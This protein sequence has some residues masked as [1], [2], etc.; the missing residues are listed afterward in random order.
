MRAVTLPV[1]LLLSVWSVP[2]LA[3]ANAVVACLG[4]QILCNKGCSKGPTA[5]SCINLCTAKAQACAQNGGKWDASADDEDD[6]PTKRSARRQTRVAAPAEDEEEEDSSSKSASSKSSSR[7]A[8]RS[9][10]KCGTD[11]EF[12]HSWPV[13]KDNDKFKFKFRVSSDDCDQYSCRGYVNYRIHF[14][15]LSGGSSGKSTLVRYT[16][17]K[18]QRSIEVT[19]ETFP[20]GANMAINVRDVEIGEVSCSSP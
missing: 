10:G 8:S 2:A 18:G 12:V 4:G 15:W 6:R 13:D 3:Q 1:A 19:D 17:P 14:T 5:G 16:I 7:K 11:A 20:S 9:D